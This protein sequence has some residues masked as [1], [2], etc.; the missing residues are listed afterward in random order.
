MPV[1][2]CS[3]KHPPPRLSAPA[4][5][6]AE[7]NRIFKS[8]GAGGQ[9]GARLSLRSRPHSSTAANRYTQKG[10]DDLDS[11]G[12]N[13]GR[14]Y[15]PLLYRAGLSP[16]SMLNA[17]REIR[18]LELK[19]TLSPLSSPS[20][21]SPYK[22]ASSSEERSPGSSRLQAKPAKN[23]TTTSSSTTSS[24]SARKTT[25]QAATRPPSAPRPA[26][27]KSTATRPSSATR[28]AAT[29]SQPSTDGKSTTLPPKR[30]VT[31]NVRSSTLGQSTTSSVQK[32]SE[33]WNSR[34]SSAKPLRSPSS[35]S[36]PKTAA[37]PV[38]AKPFEVRA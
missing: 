16:S 4:R 33:P 2:C 19:S 14:D 13:A 36:R 10:S 25:A 8:L 5:S 18:P 6:S 27:A 1:L 21:A 26:A 17:Q 29:K 11:S 34:F 37:S 35:V 12:R 15:S 31:S 7:H 32:I 28:P 30:P 38:L 22:T 3:G 23:S 9:A 20:V 24:A